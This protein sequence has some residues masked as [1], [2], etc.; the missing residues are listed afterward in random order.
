MYSVVKAEDETLS[1]FNTT[2]VLNR[3][4]TRRDRDRRHREFLQGEY[5]SEAESTKKTVIRNKISNL[6]TLNPFLPY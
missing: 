3:N 2:E 1:L 6:Q 5:L 4:G